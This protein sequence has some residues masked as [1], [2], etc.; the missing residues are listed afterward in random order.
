VN[1]EHRLQDEE[2]AETTYRPVACDKTY[3]LIAAAKIWRGNRADLLSTTPLLLLS[4]NDCNARRP[5][6]VGCN[7]CNQENL[8]AQ[9]GRRAALTAPV[10]NL[11]SNWALW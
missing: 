8:N 10:D 9:S 3:R 5:R 6:L 11:E 2:V 7:A 1:Q 4:D